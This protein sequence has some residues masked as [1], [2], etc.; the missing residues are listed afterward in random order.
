MAMLH[1][2][3]FVSTAALL[4]FAMYASIAGS[5]IEVLPAIAAA[6]VAAD[7]GTV[8][9]GATM[10]P[11]LQNQHTTEASSAAEPA[12]AVDRDSTA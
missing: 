4:S 7:T 5:L 6:A 12:P 3:Y 2:A 1:S 9:A 11:E 10:L 8:R